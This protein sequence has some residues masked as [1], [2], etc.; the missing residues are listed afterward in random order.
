[1]KIET[2]AEEVRA[3]HPFVDTHSV[4]VLGYMPNP[5]DWAALHRTLTAYIINGRHPSGPSTLLVVQEG[6]T[7]GAFYTTPDVLATYG[8][9]A[10]IGSASPADPMSAP[11]PVAPPATWTGRE[12]R[13][14]WV[15]R[16]FTAGELAKVYR[17]LHDGHGL[18]RATCTDVETKEQKSLAGAKP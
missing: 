18:R 10:G 3:A 5:D 16:N 15:L 1:M 8:P 9:F 11:L 6:S 7:L 4:A 12:D 14:A 13:V 2:F 17:L